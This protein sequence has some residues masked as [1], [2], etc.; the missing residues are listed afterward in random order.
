MQ[1]LIVG[2]TL[3][4]Y[5]F[6]LIECLRKLAIICLPIFFR[7]AGSV[8][9]LIFGLMVCFLTFGTLMLY[10]PYVEKEDNFLAS[11]CQV[12][13]FFVL[14]SSVALKY[15]TGSLE[16][17]TNVDI[18]LSVLTII[19]FAFTIFFE[20]PLRGLAKEESRAKLRRSVSGS[21]LARSMSGALR[22]VPSSGGAP[23][24]ATS[25]EVAVSASSELPPPVHDEA[26]SP[27]PA[28]DEEDA[29]AAAAPRSDP[30]EGT[31]P[32]APVRAMAD[33]A[34]PRGEALVASPAQPARRAKL[35]GLRVA[36]R[37]QPAAASRGS[38]PSPPQPSPQ[39][40]HANFRF[41]SKPIGMGL[42]DE[43]EEVIVKD[44]EEGSLA[45][46]TGVPLGCT[47]LEVNG[48]SVER[49][50]A[51]AVRELVAAAPLPLLL[52]VRM[53]RRPSALRPLPGAD[54]V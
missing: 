26:A 47:V 38:R 33:D 39:P 31:H 53:P 48:Q 36:V 25:V 54:S 7:P 37:R 51:V 4:T 18:L 28:Q 40:T 24:S 19:C 27:R 14:L 35:P 43:G 29:T 2:Y 1:K 30:P 8:A 5:D 16:E 13:I 15:D 42:G 10:A 52:A 22:H 49:M 46:R 50:D 17:A 20:T 9:Q 6:E 23:L 21:R 45:L 3:R 44:V 12:Q 32:R 11:M 34:S 41:E